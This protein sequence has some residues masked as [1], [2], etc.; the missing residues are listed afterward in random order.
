MA[1]SRTVSEIDCDF[2]RKSQIIATVYFTSL[3]TEFPLELG[4]DARGQ[5]YNDV[6]TG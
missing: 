4:T 6:A 3:L 2:S 5:N 1:L